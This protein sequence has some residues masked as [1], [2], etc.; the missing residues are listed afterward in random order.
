MGT[1]V[2]LNFLVEEEKQRQQ[3]LLVTKRKYV[4]FSGKF[5]SWQ[6]FVEESM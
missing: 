3:L 5:F 4:T 2:A 6:Q 1:G